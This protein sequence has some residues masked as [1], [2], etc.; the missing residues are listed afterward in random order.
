MSPKM[1]IPLKTITKR[2][3]LRPVRLWLQYFLLLCRTGIR[4]KI[5]LIRMKKKLFSSRAYIFHNYCPGL[6]YP[7]HRE[8]NVI[9]GSIAFC[10]P[11]GA[12][13]TP[14]PFLYFLPIRI[15]GWIRIVSTRAFEQRW[16]VKE[17]SYTFTPGRQEQFYLQSIYSHATS[18]SPW[19]NA[20]RHKTGPTFLGW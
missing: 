2:K 9:T 20:G 19:W 17:R 16:R 5:L 14:I 6:I 18:S 13:S 8:I 10:Q 12:V 3:P 11:V 15:I 7:L 4:P 1:T